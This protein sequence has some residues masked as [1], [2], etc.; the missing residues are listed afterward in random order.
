MVSCSGPHSR[1]RS[2]EEP[3]YCRSLPV[4]PCCHCHTPTLEPVR[5]C[6][7]RLSR[8]VETTVTAGWGNRTCL[9]VTERRTRSTNHTCDHV[10]L[11]FGPY[12]ATCRLAVPTTQPARPVATNLGVQN[13]DHKFEQFSLPSVVMIT[14]P[15]CLAPKCATQ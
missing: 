7:Y 8:R 2:M 13:P 14:L 15:A 12:S 4:L 3:R 1:V 6:N 5:P 10:R 11:L 9:V